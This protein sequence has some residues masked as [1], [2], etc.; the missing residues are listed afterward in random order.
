MAIES[1]QGFS[2]QLAALVESAS[3][4]VVRVDARYR[5][6]GTGIVWASD[7]ILTA[8]H[9]V[10]R[11]EGIQVSFNGN[12]HPVELVGRDP[13]TDIA[14]LRV[15]GASL[16]PANIGDPK[17]LKLGHLVAA[18][19][20][21]WGE[22]PIASVGVVSGK[23]L[24]FRGRSRLRDGLIQTDLVLYPGFSGGPLIDASGRVVGMNSATLG[25]G[26][27][28]AVPADTAGQVV[29]AL[30][31]EG[32]V[33]RGYIGVNLQIV[34][35]SEK[36]AKALAMQQGRALMILAT[37][38]GSPAEKAGLLPGDMLVKIGD[39]ILEGIEDLQRYLSADQV[40]NTMTVTIVRG[41]Q[42]KE[43]GLTVGAR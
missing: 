43:L 24:G 12:S 26:I 14:A 31:H 7:V 17:A 29:T 10:E 37:E 30:L 33:R 15:K 32:R 4:S 35:V 3:K 36:L 38:S 8:D 21:P 42:I 22:E 9:V 11:E 18:L 34:P 16:T 27:S 40:G 6:A 25:R 20:R 23:G 28:F 1:L 13:S 19:G 39:Q 41:G 2:D 5:I